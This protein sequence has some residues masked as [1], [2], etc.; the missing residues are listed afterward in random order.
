MRCLQ[1]QMHEDWICEV[2][3][4]WLDGSVRAVGRET[5][6]L[7]NYQFHRS[8]RKFRKVIDYG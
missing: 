3:D 1:A 7:L 6:W 8:L 4:D 5:A 2:R